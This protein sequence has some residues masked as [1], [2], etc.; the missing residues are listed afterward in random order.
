MRFGHRI[1]KA[2]DAFRCDCGTLKILALVG[3]SETIRE[4]FD[5]LGIVI[6]GLAMAFAGGATRDLR[7]ARV[8]LALQ[9]PI[10]IWLGLFGVEGITTVNA[11]GGDVFA[12]VLKRYSPS[13]R[14]F[15]I[16]K[17]SFII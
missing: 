10:E 13:S 14:C 11:V 9:S 12:D 4:E 16:F 3:S 7:I 6:V 1:Q 17:Y 5:L 2:F 8:P 15:I